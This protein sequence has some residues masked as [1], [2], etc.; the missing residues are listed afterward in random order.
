MAQ[1][2]ACEAGDCSQRCGL[3]E[4]A[5]VRRATRATRASSPCDAMRRAV[6]SRSLWTTQGARRVRIVCQVSR[7]W[8]T[9][10]SIARALH[11]LPGAQC[12]L[13][14]PALRRAT[15]TPCTQGSVPFAG[16]SSS[17][18]K[19]IFVP[20]LALPH[21]SVGPAERRNKRARLSHLSHPKRASALGAKTMKVIVRTPL[22]PKDDRH[23]VCHHRTSNTPGQVIT[24]TIIH[25]PIRWL[26]C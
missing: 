1:A 4:Q 20:L 25:C 15:C 10:K 5:G 18:A 3:C 11:N 8:L 24:R 6:V 16:K 21:E 22:S 13:Q 26:F 23:A 9:I 12:G 17:S 2:R 7:T 14:R 19:P